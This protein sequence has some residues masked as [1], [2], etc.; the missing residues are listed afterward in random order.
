MGRH[1]RLLLDRAERPAERGHLCLGVG[2]P[3][4][5]RTSPSCLAVGAERAEE[6]RLHNREERGAVRGHMPGGEEVHMPD[7]LSRNLLLDMARID[8]QKLF[9]QYH[10]LTY[11]TYKYKL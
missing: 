9:H 11:H 8:T 1:L 7:T 5:C 10:V 4:V 2:P 3:A 6:L